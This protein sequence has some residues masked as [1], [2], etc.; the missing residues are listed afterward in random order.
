MAKKIQAW[1][2][3]GP[4]I[5]LGNPMKK[6]ELI[7]NIIAATNQ[8]RGSVL[9]VLSELDVQI[10]AGLKAGRIVQL[11]NGTHFEPIGKKDGSVDI[12]VRVNP[13]LDKKVNAAFRGTWVNSGNIGKTEAE[14]VALWNEEHPDD[15]IPVD[16]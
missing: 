16:D 12:G 1:A 10:E 7:E 6:E 8:S 9:A 15:Q 2:A 13:D 11:P 14:I 5:E 4:K 3:Y